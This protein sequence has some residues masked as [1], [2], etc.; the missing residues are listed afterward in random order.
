MFAARYGNAE[1]VR[2]LIQHGAQV[3]L[4]ESRD[5]EEPNALGAAAVQGH[6][7]VVQLLL[8]AG[9]DTTIRNGAGKT[10]KDFAQAAGHGEVAAILRRAEQGARA[11]Q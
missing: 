4:N 10:A 8:E 5:P 9:A 1:L 6:V 3:N 2:Q 11:D 7:E